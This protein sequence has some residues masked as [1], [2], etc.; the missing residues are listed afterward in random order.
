MDTFIIT[1]EPKEQFD[2]KGKSLGMGHK[3]A[4]FYSP[5]VGRTRVYRNSFSSPQGNL[6]I[7]EYKSRSYAQKIC[8][9]VNKNLGEDFKVEQVNTNLKQ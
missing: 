1:S 4:L 7:L 8:D 2:F 5:S 9:R 3:R 6:K